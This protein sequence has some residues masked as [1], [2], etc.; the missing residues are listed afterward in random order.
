MPENGSRDPLDTLLERM[1]GASPPSELAERI[2]ASIHTRR[3]RRQG[4]HL[5]LSLGLLLT[6]IWLFAPALLAAAGSVN[7]PPSGMPWLASWLGLALNDAAAFTSE[8]AA[9]FLTPA[10]T[11]GGLAGPASLGGLA[12]L[13]TGALLAMQSLLPR[14]DW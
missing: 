2:I 14:R 4:V 11:P 3:R 13:G 5:A 6:G 10:G 8:L 1:P 9:A 7:L 12:A